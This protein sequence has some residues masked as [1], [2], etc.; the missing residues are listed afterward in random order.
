MTIKTT[1]T[2]VTA[3]STIPLA[4]AIPAALRGTLHRLTVKQVDGTL[5]GFTVD[6]YDCDPDDLPDD[7]DAAMHKLTSTKTV[8]ALSSTTENYAMGVAYENQELK[9]S[10][11][12][13]RQ[14]R[15]YVVITAAGEDDKDFQIAI[16]TEAA[17][18]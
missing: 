8:A 7:D 14:S 3:A 13:R 1:V 5:A 11:S 10:T 2:H 16:T 17:S 9:D 12:L 6:V 18:L 4:T 15:L